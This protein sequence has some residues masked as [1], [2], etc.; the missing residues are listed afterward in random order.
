MPTVRGETAASTAT[1]SRQK[2]SGSMSA[3]TGVAPVSATELA[4]AAKVKDGTITSSPGPTPA[5][6]RPRC[7]ALVP[8]LTATHGRPSTSAENSSSNAATSGPC[9]TMPLAR[10]RS[11]ARRS[12]S[13]IIGF[14]AGIAPVLMS[15][16][17]RPRAG[18]PRSPHTR[19]RCGDI[20]TARH[21]CPRG[22]RRHGRPS[23]SAEPVRRP[24]A[25]SRERP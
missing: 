8:E 3:N 13:P 9:T 7:S 22:V 21:P 16:R 5:A 2:W 4:V 12:S 6:S 20:P 19:C 1:G 10:T 17:F 25:R 14:A 24:S 18:C 11:T 15:S 23:R